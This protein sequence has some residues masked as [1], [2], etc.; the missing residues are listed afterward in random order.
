MGGRLKW[1]AV[2]LG[3]LLRSTE[4]VGAE[5]HRSQGPTECGTYE[6]SRGHEE[7][8]GKRTLVV[9]CHEAVAVADLFLV[10]QTSNAKDVTTLQSMTLGCKMKRMLPAFF[11]R[12]RVPLV[13]TF[14]DVKCCRHVP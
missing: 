3:R 5:S 14:R 6:E 12:Y 9:A 1:H 4:G 8:R 13:S 11:S 2:R 10:R 7:S